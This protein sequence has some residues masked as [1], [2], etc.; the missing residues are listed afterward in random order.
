MRDPSRSSRSETVE[1]PSA[2]EG[3]KQHCT[4]PSC[5]LPLKEGNRRMRSR[6]KTGT[7]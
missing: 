2:S 7:T 3:E 6:R 1:S 5:G 4:E